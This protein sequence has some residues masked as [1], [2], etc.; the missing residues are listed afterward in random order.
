[1]EA[2]QKAERVFCLF[3]FGEAVL[4]FALERSSFYSVLS[5]QC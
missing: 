5:S 4:S 1:M 2:F 3:A